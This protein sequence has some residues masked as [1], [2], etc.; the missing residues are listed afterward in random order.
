MVKKRPG[1]RV[2]VVD[3]NHLIRWLLTL[4]LEAG[5]HEAVEAESAED[6]LAFG[7]E[8][9]PDAWIVDEVMPGMTGSELVRAIRRSLDPRLSAAPI[10]GI[11]GRA[12]ASADLLRAGCDAFVPKP[13][14]EVWIL[15]ALGQAVRGRRSPLLD[16]PA[17]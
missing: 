5:G 11:S 7:R 6:A 16:A 8:T 2:L 12:G 17:A 15:A 3:D 13:V 4:I 10:L 1:L 9:P 14:D